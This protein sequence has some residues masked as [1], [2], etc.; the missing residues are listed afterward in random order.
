VTDVWGTW[1]INTAWGWRNGEDAPELLV[2]WDSW[3]FD[4]NEDGFHEA[5][6]ASLTDN[7]IDAKTLRLVMLNVSGDRIMELYEP[8]AIDAQVD[9]NA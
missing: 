8:L 9:A 7:Q 3:S 4:Q 5:V 6:A 1:H 2:A